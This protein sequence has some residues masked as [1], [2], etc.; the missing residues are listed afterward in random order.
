VLI[1]SWYMLRMHQGMM[2]G[3]VRAVT[4]KV[5]DLRFREGLVLAPLAVLIIL[6]GVY[7]HPVGSVAAQA[8]P[9]YVRLADTSQQPVVMPTSA[10]IATLT[11]VER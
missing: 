7:P 3:P 8:V 11:E 2:H 6:L 4:E 9:G 5:Q 1:A 10:H